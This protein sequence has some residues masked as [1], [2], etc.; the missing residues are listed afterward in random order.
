MFASSAPPLEKQRSFLFAQGFLGDAG[1]KLEHAYLLT[2]PETFKELQMLSFC[3]PG[4]AREYIEQLSTVLFTD[5]LHAF[6]TAGK[7]EAL[8]VKWQY[9]VLCATAGVAKPAATPPAWMSGLRAVFKLLDKAL[10][11]GLLEEDNCQYFQSLYSLL[12]TALRD[13]TVATTLLEAEQHAMRLGSSKNMTPTRRAKVEASFNEAWAKA[14]GMVQSL[15]KDKKPLFNGWRTPLE[16]SVAKAFL[17]EAW[18]QQHMLGDPLL[19]FFYYMEL[20][21]RQ[22][23]AGIHPPL[24]IGASSSSSFVGGGGEPKQEQKQD[25]ESEDEDEDDDVPLMSLT[26]KPAKKKPS[27]GETKVILHTPENKT[28]VVLQQQKQQQFQ[29][30]AALLGRFGL[31]MGNPAQSVVSD[32][33]REQQL[34]SWEPTLADETKS[35]VLYYDPLGAA[36]DQKKGAG[37]TANQT[38]SDRPKHLHVNAPRGGQRQPGLLPRN[39]KREPTTR[40]PQKPSRYNNNNNNYNHNNKRNRDGKEESWPASA[41]RPRTGDR[42]A[43][44]GKFQDGYL[45]E[46]PFSA[47]K[48]FSLQGGNKEKK[49]APAAAAAVTPST[50]GSDNNANDDDEYTLISP[51]K[52][53]HYGRY[54]REQKQRQDDE[55]TSPQENG[56]PEEGEIDTDQPVRRP[57]PA[58]P[59]VTTDSVVDLVTSTEAGAEPLHLPGDGE[60][61]VETGGLNIFETIMASD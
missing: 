19:A 36:A 24:W 43:K 22:A 18:L 51:P 11:K 29:P 34:K 45:N 53:I 25:D 5:E 55:P 37:S 21:A 2:D 16:P 26:A 3:R 39:E 23:F 49:R 8:N 27:P 28:Y 44:E 14:M 10:V 7:N 31:C 57:G 50:P 1:N 41:K 38:V 47:G 42:D 4:P 61:P 40:F 12:V 32:T 59:A 52:D 48:Q 60:Q 6:T 58:E 13:D 15:P 46:P 30:G 9:E 17:S 33:V 20:F 54:S 35:L 56:V